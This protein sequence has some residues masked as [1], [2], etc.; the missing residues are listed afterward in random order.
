MG[1]PLK[2]THTHTQE[3][4]QVLFCGWDRMPFFRAS[5][6]ARKVDPTRSLATVFWA[7]PLGRREFGSRSSQERLLGGLA[8]NNYETA[9]RH[10]P[11]YHTS[12]GC[13]D[14]PKAEDDF[15]I[16]LRVG[17]RTTPDH[18]H[19]PTRRR[20]TCRLLIFATFFWNFPGSQANPWLAWIEQMNSKWVA[21]LFP[22]QGSEVSVTISSQR[23]GVPTS[24][25]QPPLNCSPKN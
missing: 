16:V 21:K 20:A 13:G 23:L 14:T 8:E 2:S 17:G 24:I 18:F 9:F 22:A 10:A 19:S 3:G 11:K 25:S 1:G 12:T 15:T 7:N 6:S 5:A 4:I